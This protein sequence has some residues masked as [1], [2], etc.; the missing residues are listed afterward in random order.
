[1]EFS[2]YKIVEHFNGIYIRFASEG[3]GNESSVPVKG[4]GKAAVIIVKKRCNK[5]FMDSQFLFKP[6]FATHD[7]SPLFSIKNG[8]PFYPDIPFAN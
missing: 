3:S 7:L 5:R 4:P 2:F 8:M 6:V 1:L